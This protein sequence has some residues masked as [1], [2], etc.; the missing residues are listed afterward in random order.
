MPSTRVAMNKR[1]CLGAVLAA[2]LSLLCAPVG[3]VGAVAPLPESNYSVRAT[4]AAAAP[5]DAGCMALELVPQTVAARAH[6]HPLGFTRS[7]PIRAVKASEGSFGLRPQDLHSAYRLPL[8]TPSTQTIALV[9]AY[10]DPTAE[11]DLEAYD[12]EFGLPACTTGN[13]CFRQVNEHG[14]GGSSNLPFPQT[15]T[16]LTAAEVTC[17]NPLESRPIREAA[18]REV[19]AA[20]GWAGEISLDIEVAH[21]TC[22]NCRVVLVEAATPSFA[23]FEAAEQAAVELNATEISNSWGGAASY[24]SSAFDHPGIVITASAGDYGY[25]NLDSHNSSERGYP[26][27]PASSPHVVAVGG[28]RL[29]VVAGAWAGETVWN[30]QGAGGGGCSA[31]FPAQPW[32]SN[33][34]DWSS[35]GCGPH[36][37]VAD[38]SADADPHTGVA[39][40]DSE[41]ECEYEEAHVLHVTH[42]CTFGGTSLSSPLIASAFALAGGSG[43]VEYPART[44]YENALNN[45]GSLHDVVSGS[46]GACAKPPKAGGLSGCTLA[47]EESSCSS[48]LI[49]LATT[50]YDGPTGV[51]TPDGL[52]A[53][54]SGGEAASKES[55]N[56]LPTTEAPGNEGEAKPGTNGG[57]PGN[58]KSVPSQSSIELSGLRLTLDAIVALNRSQPKVSQVG[59]VFTITAA[60]RV[61]VT[62]ARRIRMRGHMR[63]RQLSSSLTFSATPG[64]NS[65]HLKGRAIL[66]PGLY[67]LTLTPAH[68]TA[69]SLTFHLG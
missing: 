28:T 16:E 11:A 44:L 9:D 45:P 19:E 20:T 61:R 47:E 6:T 30:G 29:S 4:C 66:A 14:E 64:R 39:V 33:L 32:Q 56:E 37:A 41:S 22:E 27:Y 35:V 52:A 38:V 10:N 49:C 24:D 25:L 67:R 15:T 59:F 65:R 18:C 51:G 57:S 68:G 8:T 21:T 12:R 48:L 36:R 3:A 31:T 69:R 26:Y 40:Y 23:D 2:G 7:S 63:W 42:W 54:V 46:N 58:T 1:T 50:G 13:G 5:G 55:V 62:L 34:S 53:F 17:A 43:G 60:T